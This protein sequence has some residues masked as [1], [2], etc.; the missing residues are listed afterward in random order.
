MARSHAATPLGIGSIELCPVPPSPGLRP[1]Y[2]PATQV[3]YSS[4]FF[5]TYHVNH[6]ASDGCRSS[7]LA[8]SGS[9]PSVSVDRLAMLHHTRRVCLRLG[10]RM[11]LSSRSNNAEA[12]L[13]SYAAAY[14]GLRVHLHTSQDS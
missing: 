4:R 12:F 8:S 14:R 10:A 1:S 2:L 13:F 3:P 9:S 7:V 6:G 5:H 11:L